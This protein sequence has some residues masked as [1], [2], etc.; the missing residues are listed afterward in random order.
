MSVTDF[1]HRITSMMAKL[2]ALALSLET[3]A[4]ENYEMAIWYILAA[5]YVAILDLR[6]FPAESRK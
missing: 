5:I 4:N 2:G 6:W 3:L 1:L